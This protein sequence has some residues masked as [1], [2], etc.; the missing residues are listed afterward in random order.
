MCKFD[1]EK[2]EKVKNNKLGINNKKQ[3]TKTLNNF[4]C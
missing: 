3:L 4:I 2:E 1:K